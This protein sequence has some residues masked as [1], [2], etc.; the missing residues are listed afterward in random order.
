MNVRPKKYLGQHFLT[1]ER[2]A[3]RIVD[4]LAQAIP[5]YPTAEVMEIGPGKG[6]LTR[7]LIG[8]GRP[9]RVIE[10]DSESVQYLR[11]HYPPLEIIEQ[12]V[13][14]YDFSKHQT[15]I[16]LISNLPYNISSPLCFHLLAHRAAI[17][18]A[19]LMFQ[20]EVAQRICATPGQKIYG[21]LSV[22]LGYYYELNYCMTVKA[23]SF[24]PKP[25]VDSGVVR[26]LRRER[27]WPVE[28]ALFQQVVKL[29]F[30]QRRKMLSNAL[31]SLGL[32]VPA[33]FADRRAEELTPAQFEELAL[34]YQ[35]H[36]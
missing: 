35:S 19:V 16:A 6:V 29:A 4:L 30:N 21:M 11:A 36:R 18:L 10:I 26:L 9:L 7:N 13:L 15:P 14:T 12:D 28:A 2:I 22:L 34:Y 8:I 33:A 17:P 27:E 25:Q 23:G 32:P 5:A 3:A 31:S 1:D 20:K 24:F